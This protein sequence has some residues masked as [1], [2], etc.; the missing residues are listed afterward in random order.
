MKWSWFGRA[1]MALGA[2][3]GLALGMTGCGIGTIAYI[4][5]IGETSN[6]PTGVI[7]G[8]KVD[9]NTGNLTAIPHSPFGTNGSVPV[10][11]LV[12]PGGRYVY[13]V[14]QGTGGTS[15][16][17]GSGDGVGVFAVGGS[18]TLTFQEPYE[19][20]GF[21][22]LWAQFDSTG[23]YLAVLDQY[24]PTGDGNGAITVFSVD[25]TTGRLNPVSQQ[26][27]TPSGGLSLPYL[28]VGQKP[29]RMFSTGDCLYTINSA[30]QSITPYSFASGQ[31]GT[32]TTG[33]IF[34]G[35][36]QMTSINGNPNNVFITDAGLNMIFPF[37]KT[38][39]CGL[40]TYTGGPVKNDASATNPVY[41]FI[42]Q[43]QHYLFVL[44]QSTTS[45]SPGKAYSSITIFTITSG[46][47]TLP[48]T[49]TVGSGP[50]C[51]VEDPTQQYV[52]V[53]NY[54][55]GSITGYRFSSTEG[56]LAALTRGSTFTAT[57][58]A[59]CLALSP[60]VT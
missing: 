8:F 26:A 51:M 20:Q 19:T 58:N 22:H 7:A 35:T 28:E 36:K 40:T 38:T 33:K 5:V 25:A 54:N 49:Y 29:L 32:V 46:E 21:N 31:L 23:N 10:S 17:N 24:S 45:T 1:A 47:L 34:P 57:G 55:D 9:N 42:D 59:S 15:T 13:V 14:N 41:S 3:L 43:S 11:I 6:T 30:D 27:S 16:A 56:T 52:Y 60:N 50:T 2:A 48:S 37:T 53:S 18:G 39:G 12:K 4:W 44:N